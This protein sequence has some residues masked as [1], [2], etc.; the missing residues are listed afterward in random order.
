MVT[1]GFIGIL[2]G[3]ASFLLGNAYIENKNLDTALACFKNYYDISKRD[4][5]E[6]NF[7]IASEALAKCFEK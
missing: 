3:Q 1:K 7:G 6:E 4:K 5:D 2:E